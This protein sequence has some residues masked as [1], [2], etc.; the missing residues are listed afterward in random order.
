MSTKILYIFFL[1][2][3]KAHAMRTGYPLPYIFPPQQAKQQEQ[4][5]A[6][7]HDSPEGEPLAG[8][9]QKN[10]ESKNIMYSDN[11]P[12]GFMPAGKPGLEK[13]VRLSPPPITSSQVAASKEIQRRTLREVLGGF[14]EIP[15]HGLPEGTREVPSY[16]SQFSRAGEVC[17]SSSP[18][19][20]QEQRHQLL[21]Q[22]SPGFRTTRQ[23]RCTSCSDNPSRSLESA[24]KPDSTVSA[25]REVH[26]LQV[27]TGRK[28]R[29]NA[30]S[31]SCCSTAR[32]SG[33]RDSAA[34]GGRQKIPVENA[35]A[36]ADSDGL[37]QVLR[38]LW[39]MLRKHQRAAAQAV[40]EMEE[41]EG[42]NAEAI[43]DLEQ[44]LQE[45]ER[46]L[47]TH[48]E[49]GLLLQHSIASVTKSILEA[50]EDLRLAIHHLMR[51]HPST[52]NAPPPMPGCL[53][54][55]DLMELAAESLDSAEA[56]EAASELMR[57]SVEVKKAQ[58]AEKEAVQTVETLRRQLLCLQRARRKQALYKRM[59]LLQEKYQAIEQRQGELQQL[60][61]WWEAYGERQ[62]LHEHRQAALLVQRRSARRGSSVSTS[63]VAPPATTAASVLRCLS[64]YLQK[65]ELELSQPAATDTPEPP[66]WRAMRCC[67]RESVRLPL[68][69]AYPHDHAAVSSG[70]LKLLEE[71]V[72]V[73]SAVKEQGTPCTCSGVNSVSA[74]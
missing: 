52:P 12:Y 38:G 65:Q 47:S 1:E 26:P 8:L 53:D 17:S 10:I 43:R 49:R 9:Q 31:P 50:E 48:P 22:P 6:T 42:V 73:S 28:A 4:V 36:E 46:K 66:R 64:P 58:K 20:H 63:G 29:V 5:E 19:Q 34:D 59:Q 35:A 54:A 18:R 39:Q 51:M 67:R 25:Q 24:G 68:S 60:Q 32:S 45:G 40:H 21:N 72:A 15:F 70:S 11:P 14:M 33:D 16:R 56:A 55:E 3:L 62:L 41:K 7:E 61:H 13:I 37:P 23:R 2:T 69:S 74:E 44:R 30:A 71:F 57:V 27:A